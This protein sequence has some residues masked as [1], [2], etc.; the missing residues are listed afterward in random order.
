MASLFLLVVCGADEHACDDPTCGG[1][2][3]CVRGVCMCDAGFQGAKCEIKGCPGLPKPCSGIGK[4]IAVAIA[5]DSAEFNAAAAAKTST[6]SA[7]LWLSASQRHTGVAVDNSTNA[8][9]VARLSARYHAAVASATPSLAPLTLARC[10]CP[11]GRGGLACEQLTCP[12]GLATGAGAG[13]GHLPCSGNGA[14]D[15]RSGTCLCT[16]PWSGPN[17]SLRGCATNCSSHGTCDPQ[18]GSCV[19]ED[20]WG[21]PLCERPGCAIV[22]LLE[23]AGPSHGW[24]DTRRRTC[25]CAAGW[26][27]IACATP[28]PPRCPNNCSGHGACS[29]PGAMSAPAIAAGALEG[30]VLAGGGCV[31]DPGWRG[32]DCSRPAC[33]NDCSGHGGC[34][35]DGTCLCDAGWS[36][37]S[38]DVGECPNDC[39]GHGSCLPTGE[40]ACFVGFGGLDCSRH[41][42][43]GD[44]GA[45]EG[46]GDCVDGGCRCRS[47]WSGEAC[48]RPTCKVGCSGRGLCLGGGGASAKC[49]CRDGFF[50][51]ACEHGCLHGCSKRGVCTPEGTCQCGG[52]WRG[53]DCSVPPMRLD[54]CAPKC[55]A[56]CSRQCEPE[57]HD[58]P[59]AAS[60]MEEGLGG[61]SSAASSSSASMVEQS[62]DH[63]HRR[64]PLAAADGFLWRGERSDKWA[65][66][67]ACSAECIARCEEDESEAELVE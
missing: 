37:A 60:R 10:Q 36:G 55:A 51:E 33:P 53:P 52:G 11:P 54:G 41:R 42:C 65:C 22:G 15:S 13:A 58:G 16:P 34:R 47:G 64:S 66:A 3:T 30:R 28:L 17:C 38:C 44:C 2:G 24:C 7:S 32:V 29:G 43:V 6:S 5:G 35:H 19:C 26:G 59:A 20:G 1:H 18:S 4:C 49:V 67:R 63:G 50:G 21:G 45:L 62:G 46:R 14:C 40:C 8:T 57:L 27:G 61:S 39:D 12:T 23:C 56:T 25:V 9:Q 48:D 31:C